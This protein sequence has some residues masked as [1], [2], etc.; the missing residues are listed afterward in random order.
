MSIFFWEK[1]AKSTNPL[2]LVA[3]RFIMSVKSWRSSSVQTPVSSMWNISSCERGLSYCGM[4]SEFFS[5][6]ACHFAFWSWIIE[7]EGCF[8]SIA[9][10]SL[11]SLSTSFWPSWLSSTSKSSFSSTLTSFQ[12]GWAY[13]EIGAWRSYTLY[14]FSLTVPVCEIFREWETTSGYWFKT[15]LN[16]SP[17]IYF[18]G[19]GRP[20]L[21]W[22]FL[23]PL[24]ST[25]CW[26]LLLCLLMSLKWLFDSWVAS[27]S[28]AL[29]VKACLSVWHCLMVMLFCSSRLSLVIFK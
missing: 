10:I 29:C 13:Y 8:Y 26:R 12:I 17:T 6:D 9:R 20:L 14:I 11:C 4:L 3:N 28:N 21:S 15:N 22:V 19:V 25:N 5:P 2:N 18:T 16:S 1:G 24:D 23:N 27:E 7:E